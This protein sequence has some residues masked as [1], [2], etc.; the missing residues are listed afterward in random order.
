MSTECTLIFWFSGG[1]GGIFENYGAYQR[2]VRT[3]LT[4]AK[5]FKEMLDLC[6]MLDDPERPKSGKHRDL[7][8]AEIKKSEEAVQSIM[9]AIS[10]L[11]KSLEDC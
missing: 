11:K 4:R 3:T 6:D 9:E 5:M 1:F 2:W 8:A 7:E 10:I